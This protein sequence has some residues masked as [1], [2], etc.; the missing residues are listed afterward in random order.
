[1][2][3]TD[4]NEKYLK[5][6]IIKTVAFFDLFK[7]P[8]TVLEVY[9]YLYAPGGVGKGIAE[10][11]QSLG[12]LSRENI[13]SQKNGFY[14]LKGRE[15][16]AAERQKRYNR[17]GRKIKEAKKIIRVFSALPWIKMIALGNVMGPRNFKKE[18]DIDFFI[19]A[20][21]NRIWITRFFSAGLAALL[22]LRPREGRTEDK[23]CLSFF[24]SEDCLELSA[25]SD[26]PELLSGADGSAAGSRPADIYFVYW[27]AGLTPL[28]DRGDIFRKLHKSNPWL[29]RCLPNV[30]AC[31][32]AKE[33]R[34]ERPLLAAIAG[35]FIGLL[36]GWSEPLAKRI[37]LKVFPPAIREKINQGTE[38][39]VNDRV[40][41]LHVNDRRIKYRLRWESKVCQALAKTDKPRSQT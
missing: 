12:E 2:S 28:Y 24:M 37:Q 21:K 30:E 34:F 22:G 15:E 17:S 3:Y 35:K 39:V 19:V 8:L 40:I 11:E 32:L 6:A 41:K 4:N 26:S 23:I 27:L 29:K 10:V 31:L 20:E 16:I 25:L 14:F 7:Y 36:T 18:S 9:K 13:L 1:M 38:V 33:D 5:E